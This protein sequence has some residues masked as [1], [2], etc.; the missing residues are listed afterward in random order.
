MTP[1]ETGGAGDVRPG[2][3]LGPMDLHLLAE[4]THYRLYEKLG[5]HPG[6]HEGEEGTWFSVWA[7]DARSVHV[8][9]DF[10]R[11]DPARHPLAPVERSG[12][13]SGFLP[14][15]REG[16]LYKYRVASRVSD[17]VADKADPFGFMHEAP[18]RTASVVRR[19]DYEWG[20]GAWMAARGEA[21]RLDR[22]LSVYEVHLG[23]FPPPGKRKGFPGYRELAPLIA[24]HAERGGFTHVELLPVMEHPFYGSWGY[25]I[26]GYYAPTR[27]HGTPQDFMAFVDHLHRRGLG[28]ILDWV[29][30]HFPKDAHGLA[31]FD[32]THLY[33]HADP[34]LGVHPDW[35]SL[36][37]NYGR[38]EVVCFLVSNA[39]FWL[40]RYHADGL[41][42][43]AVASML[44]RDYSRREGEWIPNR[45]GGR[46]NLEAIEFLKRLNREVYR[47]FPD[48]Q[49]IAEESTAW[50]LVT[51]PVHEGGLGF[52][53]KWDM[54]WMHDSLRYFGRDPAHREHHHRE[55]TF[56]GLYQFTEN[57]VLPLS[58]D[59]VVHG[60]GSLLSR[61]PG[62]EWRRFAN[63]RL[64]LAWMWMQTGKKLLFMG[65]EL[66]Q[67][68]E[69]D[70]HGGLDPA[71]LEKPLHAG[72]FR[73]VAELNRLYREEPALHEMDCDPRGFEWV[74]A[75]D[76][77]H[78]VVAFLRKGRRP[79]RALL[80][81]LNCTPVPREDYRLGV[82][83]GGPWRE[84][85]NT[86][87]AEFG[88]S[89]VG[90]PGGPEAREIPR[91][92]LPFS[93]ALR[94]PPL[95]ALLLGP[96]SPPPDGP[97]P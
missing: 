41:R 37:F 9:G 12:V 87:A 53:L 28:V 58:H 76:A 8:I 3:L 86:D 20:D 88:G 61:M 32:G 40:D 54:G 91:H 85:L 39:V 16:A 66:A 62:D 79:E 89:G 75:D 65:G 97:P 93:L 44:Y 96:A 43:D 60:K 35:D 46:E 25:Q 1:R 83:R 24:D 4:G 68:T 14:G 2:S 74:E 30:S 17:H 11:W 82:P 63:L 77:E 13:W 90:N 59:E 92:G 19:L 6:I 52:G 84:I 95:G 51:R 27:R 33:E 73:L 15:V 50:P 23:S 94:L 80:A 34:R 7:P 22:P 48:V 18:P 70:H 42:V 64:L 72:V 47:S 67:E 26:T 78:S 81:V 31:F 49:T 45:Y 57:Y 55:L 10:N 38:R 36:I 29:P 21:H 69:W 56:R 5:A 71:L